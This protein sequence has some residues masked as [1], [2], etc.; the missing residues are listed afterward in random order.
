MGASYTAYLIET[1]V[2]LAVVCGLAYVVLLGARKLG[3]GRA[4]GPIELVGQL[5][6]DARRAVYLVKVG[7]QIFVVAAGEGGFTKIGELAAKDLDL[8][9][10]PKE[11]FDGVLARILG[12]PRRDTD[13][14]KQATSSAQP[15]TDGGQPT[16]DPDDGR[17]P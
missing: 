14:G 2:T 1:F 16:A 6:L 15:P 8:A 9:A 13:E 12:T 17:T 7:A 5:P 4:R 3:I 11:T 10:R